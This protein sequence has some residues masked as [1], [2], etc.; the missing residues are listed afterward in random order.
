MNLLSPVRLRELRAAAHHLQPVV[1]VAGNGLSP[2]VVAEI[3]RALTTHELIK[4]RIYG[5]DRV[6]RGELLEAICQQ[7]AAQAVQHIGNILV[8]WREKPAEAEP[9]EAP[10]RARPKASRS[11]EP[12]NFARAARAQVLA[13]AAP[14]RQAARR[15]SPTSSRSGT[16]RARSPR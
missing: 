15:A 3:D 13:A 4:V 10:V 5:E 6:Q 9:A 14:S 12:K 7:V 2:A 8:L 16:P 11:A 1:S